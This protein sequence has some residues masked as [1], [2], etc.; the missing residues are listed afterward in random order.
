MWLRSL[1]MVLPVMTGCLSHTRKVQQARMP[2][3]V[4]SATADQLVDS[5]NQQYQSINSISAS[6]EFQATEGG[7][8]KGKEKTYTSFSGYI[9]L[10]KPESLRVLG[11]VPVLHT[12]AF[13]MASDG[14]SFKLLI[15]IKNKA[16]VGSNKITK[17]STNTLENLRPGVFFDSLLIDPIGKDDLLTLTSDTQTELNPKSKQL[18]IQP[19]YNLTILRRKDESNVLVPERVIHFSRIDLHI[20]QEDI[21][22][23]DGNIETIAIYGPLQT[24]GAI[25][26]PGSITI[27]R[28]L[29]QYQILITITK[30]TVN[31]PLKDDQFELTIPE[32]TQIQKL[33]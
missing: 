1:L 23:N 16:I 32:G 13:D 27:K 21:Y 2:G 30:L 18:M 28:P 22:D 26:F 20:Y 25:K 4:L 11:L 9:L 29:E 17:K 7:S 33:D 19:D 5:I 14:N 10:R 24:F 15:P 31:L 12:R 8:L 6:V 3:V